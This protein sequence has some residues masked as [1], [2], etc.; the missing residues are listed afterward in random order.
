VFGQI[1]MQ[2]EVLSCET[3]QSRSRSI[4]RA[5]SIL[6][7]GG[8]AAFPT[9]T[10]YGL[11]VIAG[12]AAAEER[13]RE[14]KG[15]EAE[16]PFTIAVADRATVSRFVEF[17]PALGH[18]LM[19]RCWPG[20]LTVV[21]ENPHGKTVGL[22]LPA[23]EDARELIR[24]AGGAV[25]APSANR[26]GEPPARTA[27]EVLAVYDGRIEAV[28]DGG[29]AELGRPSTVVRLR[30][31]TYEILRPGALSETRLR[32]AAN[33]VVLFVCSG[34]SCRSPIAE[35]L[36]RRML[37]ERLKVSP[38]ELEEHGY[39]LISGGIA[40]GFAA[41]ASSSAIQVMHEL[42]VDISNHLSQTI[43]P[44]MVEHSDLILV[45]TADQMGSIL[46]LVPEA[47]GR[48]MLLDP[49]GRAVEDPHGG[50]LETYRR[51]AFVI[52]RALEKRVKEL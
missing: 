46:R 5:A 39:T 34:N 37:A 24:K 42:G 23:N 6:A 25:L 51:C 52:R 1:L 40:G 7:A 11:G 13:L 43:T 48:V 26:G 4:Q 21:F 32:R 9:E 35:A 20:P 29:P 22:R 2:T 17:V 45:M 27:E 33:M 44:E 15:R 36:C 3:P 47:K 28:L 8:V 30:G 10:V 16:K 14:L 49:K 19:N 50:D 38:D 31:K 18:R 12:N 41:P